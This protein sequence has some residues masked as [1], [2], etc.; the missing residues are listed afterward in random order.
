MFPLFGSYQ[1]TSREGSLGLRLL[2]AR[3]APMELTTNGGFPAIKIM[4][5]G[6]PK[7]GIREQLFTLLMCQVPPVYKPA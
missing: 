7:A 2:M 3:G 5:L 4:E 6:C 1:V